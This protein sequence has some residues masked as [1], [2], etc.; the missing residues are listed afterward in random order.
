MSVLLD[1]FTILLV[2][3]GLFFFVAGTAGLLRFP[4]TLTRLHSLTKADGLGIGLV[5]IGLLPQS[6]SLAEGLKLLAVWVVL[7]LASVTMGQLIGA[8][9]RR[10]EIRP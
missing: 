1:V 3:A 6:R 10:G 2:S 9:I 4:D 8:V 5:V 7:L